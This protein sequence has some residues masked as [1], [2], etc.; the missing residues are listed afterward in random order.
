MPFWI[1][2][3]AHARAS[4]SITNAVTV[5]GSPLPPYSFGNESPTRPS[6]ASP[7]VFGEAFQVIAQDGALGVGPAEGTAEE[8]RETDAHD[9]AEV[10]LGRRAQHALVEA[11][12]GLVG[13]EEREAPRGLRAV[14]LRAGRHTDERV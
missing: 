5:N 7:V 1:I 14:P 10:A 8:R 11:A 3:L 2:V 9:R 13:E 4:I 12:R 6:S